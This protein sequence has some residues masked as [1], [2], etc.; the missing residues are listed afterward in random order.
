MLPAISP[1]LN[2]CLALLLIVPLAGAAPR[3][4]PEGKLPDDKR[5]APPKDLDGYFPFAVPSNVKAWEARREEVRRQML[6]ALGLWPMPAPTPLNAVIHGKVERPDYTVERVYF[7]SYPGYYVTGSLY[8]PKRAAGDTTKLPVVL[9]PHGHFANGRF[10]EVALQNARNQISEGAERFESGGRF[11]LQAKCVTLARMGCVVFFYDMIGYADSLQFTHDLAHLFDVKD[12]APVTGRP[13]GIFSPQAELNL[14]SIMGLQTYSSLRALDFVC[15][16]PDVDPTRIG[17]T[18]AS[19]GGTQTMIL[20]ALDPRVTATVPAVMVSTSMQGG[21]TCENASLLRIDTG[22]I[23]FAAMFAPKPQC[24]IAADDWTKELGT[25]GLPEL[26]ALYKLLGKPENLA[27]K[28]NLHFKHNDNFVSRQIIYQWFN[29]H[30][31]LGLPA[32]VLEE[33]FE[34]L[35]VAEATVWNESHP[36]PPR[37]DEFEQKLLSEIAAAS[38]KQLAPLTDPSRQDEATQKQRQEVLLPAWQVVLGGGIPSDDDLEVEEFSDQTMGDYKLVP[39]LV[40]RKSIGSVTPIFLLSANG[41]APRGY[42]LWIDP[43]GKAGLFDES[44]Q[45][46]ADAKKLLDNDLAII[47]LDLFLQGEFLATGEPPSEITRVKNPRKYLGYTLGYNHAVFAQRVRDIVSVATIF[48]RFHL[49]PHEQLSIIGVN[50]AGKF[51]AG[52]LAVGGEVFDRAAI[53]DAGFRFANIDSIWSIDML[54]G[55]VKY[56]DIPGMLAMRADQASIH[57]ADANQPEPDR[58][59]AAIEWLLGNNG[60]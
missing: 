46:H 22:N 13:K 25:K 35:I 23:E 42:V 19:G 50:G 58:R 47:G 54:P 20:G 11:P 28:L 3:V 49:K 34:P 39:G 2:W 10:N 12:D 8:R 4:L 31:G 59:D 26:Q 48:R 41:D 30:L 5:L 17:V 1:K 33:S 29:Q 16:L 40:H 36:I 7:E 37:G 15:S 51:V 52:A 27:A 9:T 44:G 55:A 24:L 38:A 57:Q 56:G 21:C 53:D 43:R 32:P 14:Q 18:G 60:K 6:V 45:P